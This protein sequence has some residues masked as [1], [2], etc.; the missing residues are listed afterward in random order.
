[1]GSFPIDDPVKPEAATQ[2]S[3]E[4]SEVKRALLE[5]MLRGA[6]PQSPIGAVLSRVQTPVQASAA[7]SPR[8]PVAVVQRGGSKRP[9]F[10][11]HVHWQGGPLYCFNLA[12]QLGPDYPVYLLDPYRC[13]DLEAAPPVE[14]IAADYIQSMRSVQPE[15]PY[16]LG[17]FCGASV[18]AYE[19]AQQL[20]AQGEAVDLLLF[21]EPMTGPIRLSR[22]TGRVVRRLGG[23]LGLRRGQQMDWFLRLRH[24][25]RVIRRS[26]DE[27]TDGAERLMRSWCQERGRHFL[28][29]PPAGALRLDWLAVFAWPVSGYVPRPYPGRMTYILASGNPDNRQLWW[30]AVKPADNVEI[31]MVSGDNE[32][33]RTVYKDELADA[34]CQVIMRAQSAAPA[35][36]SA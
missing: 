36:P 12:R 33:C 3:P 15:G 35:S 14:V 2:K 16:L 4:L 7:E 6:L 18:T 31:H 34:M 27:F 19:M 1:M 32:S 10:Y 23:L 22:M 5:K 13:D 9:F 28:V 17:G 11:L 26:R 24:L 8:V 25:L 30:G 21:V 29:M 20:R